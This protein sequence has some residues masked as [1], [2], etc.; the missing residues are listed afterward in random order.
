VKPAIGIDLGTTSGWAARHE[1]G[2][3]Q[4]GV[5]KLKA[6][7][8]EGGGMRFLR[9]NAAMSELFDVVKPE[10]VFYE[11][12]RRHLSTDS[13]HVYGGLMATLT[14]ICEHRKIAYTGLPVQTIKKHATAKGNADKK[15]MIACARA[16]W[17]EQGIVD[18]NQADSLWVLDC[19]LQE[20]HLK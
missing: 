5:L 11:E 3:L 19:G 1:S 15:L 17:P 18:D 13:A 7:R 6:G 2:L 20:Y 4:S 9:F 16:R 12:V 14:A 8:F 10:I